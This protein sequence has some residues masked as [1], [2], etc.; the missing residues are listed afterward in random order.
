MCLVRVWVY[1]D[2][3]F[4]EF[5]VEDVVVSSITEP[6]EGLVGV[7]DSEFHDGRVVEAG[8]MDGGVE[9]SAVAGALMGREDKELRNPKSRG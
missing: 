5:G 8:G 7:F 9:M 1:V 6:V 4:D 3:V 2:L